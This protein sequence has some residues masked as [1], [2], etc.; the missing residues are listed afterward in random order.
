MRGELESTHA[1][2]G[3]TKTFLPKEDVSAVRRTLSPRT[4]LQ[5]WLQLGEAKGSSGFFSCQWNPFCYVV[6]CSIIR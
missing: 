6:S 4:A 5:K 2:Q 3:S 1:F